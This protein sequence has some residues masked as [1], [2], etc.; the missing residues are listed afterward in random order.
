[1]VED[2]SDFKGF[3]KPFFVEFLF[4][5][6]IEGYLFNLN[7]FDGCLQLS[8]PLS[9]HVLLPN[10]AFGLPVVGPNGFVKYGE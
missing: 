10:L 5:Q 4:G 2:A 6:G 8:R 9:D 1:M 7:L 3:V